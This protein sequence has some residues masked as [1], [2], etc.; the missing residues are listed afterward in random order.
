MESSHALHRV[1]FRVLYPLG[2]SLLIPFN[3]SEQYT[4]W[5]ALQVL[6][7]LIFS[8][9]PGPNLYGI[10]LVMLFISVR[11]WQESLI[12]PGPKST[13]I[14][15]SEYVSCLCQRVSDHNTFI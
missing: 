10:Y 15:F 13:H 12:C 14:L 9:L 2:N 4:K 1:R 7:L 11:I 3:V 5:H 8:I 6:C